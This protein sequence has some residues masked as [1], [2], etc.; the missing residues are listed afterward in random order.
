MILRAL[1]SM[2]RQCEIISPTSL[3][4]CR[5]QS[6]GE[7]RFGKGVFNRFRWRSSWRNY[8]MIFTVG[9]RYGFG[10]MVRCRTN[11]IAP[12]GMRAMIGLIISLIRLSALIWR[13]GMVVAESHPKVF[14]R[15]P[16]LQPHK[17]RHLFRDGSICPF[18][19]W[20]N[21]WL[22]SRDTVVDYMGHAVV[23]LIKWI[24]W[25]QT[26]VWIGP[27]MSHAPGFLLKTIQ[28]NQQCWCGSGLKY[29]K[30]HLA[31]D[32]LRLRSSH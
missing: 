17:A 32:Q 23:W 30:C 15:S 19:P 21:V 5:R 10:Q 6:R 1:R 26:G 13:S 11:P 3:Y 7:K 2:F 25:D 18:A 20:E 29:K 31:Q 27:E 24:V 12:S 9:A 8:S 14:V 28:R 22:W 16:V 4:R